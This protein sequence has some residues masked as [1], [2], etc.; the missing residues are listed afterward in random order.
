LV[1]LLVTAKFGTAALLSKY[2]DEYTFF[3]MDIWFSKS[4]LPVLVSLDGMIWDGM[5]WGFLYPA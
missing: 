3:E 4:P 1:W 5:A 2:A